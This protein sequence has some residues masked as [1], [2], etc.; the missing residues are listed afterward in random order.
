MQAQP[1]ATRLPLWS[2]RMI[3]KTLDQG[4]T[5]A[6]II[7]SKKCGR[8]NTTKKRIGLILV[9]C[10]ELPDL[11]QGSLGTF[12]ELDVVSLGFGPIPA[13]ILGGT[14]I[15]SQEG[16]INCRPQ[17]IP[18]LTLVV[19]KCIDS[20]ARK[21]WA[22]HSPFFAIL[23]GAEYKCA[24]HRTD[25]QEHIARLRIYVSCFWH[26]KVRSTRF[27]ILESA[28]IIPAAKVG[29]HSE[30][31][32]RRQEQVEREVW[33]APAVSPCSLFLLLPAAP[34]PLICLLLF[35]FCVVRFRTISYQR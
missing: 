11:F 35:A 10:N 18:A 2:M 19:K 9:T 31:R 23:V 8:L 21:I 33:P 17:P 34:A 32:S 4:P 29:R 1:S 15:R 24:L 5:L 3:V 16:T 12:R 26:K 20:A 27:R 6:C 22:T 25:E 7:G 13:K 14:Q 30:G 28:V